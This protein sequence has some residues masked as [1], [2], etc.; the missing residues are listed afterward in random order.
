M[1]ELQ[2]TLVDATN[3]DEYIV[4]RRGESIVIRRV[5]PGS[6]AHTLT[7]AAAWDFAQRLAEPK[8]LAHDRHGEDDKQD[9]LRGSGSLRD[10]GAGCLIRL[11]QNWS[12]SGSSSTTAAIRI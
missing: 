6:C 9:R 2:V 5:L 3:T 8:K 4:G 7:K 1:A 11:H 12:K 10:G